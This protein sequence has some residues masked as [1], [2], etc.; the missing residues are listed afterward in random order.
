MLQ[1]WM[2]Q[3]LGKDITELQNEFSEHESRLYT[4]LFQEVSQDQQQNRI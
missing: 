3:K 1:M 2:W 4:E